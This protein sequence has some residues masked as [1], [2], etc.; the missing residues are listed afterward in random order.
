MISRFVLALA[1]ALLMLLG[2][3]TTF[4]YLG[5]K[6]SKVTV[7][8]QKPTASTPRPQAFV[9]PGT[10][11][12]AQSGALY[13]LSA[14]RFHQLTPEAGWTQPSLSPDGNSLIVVRQSHQ[15]SDVYILNRFGTVVR[16]VT[17]NAA[18]AR[19]PD[20]GANHWSFYPRLSADGQTLWMAYDEP[21][22]G[23]D[24]VLSIWAMPV[25]GSIRQGRVWTSAN[26]Y[27]GGDV[28]PVPVPQGGAIYTK[29]DYGPDLKLIGQLWYTNRAYSYGRALTTAAEDC[30]DPAVS[31]DGTQVAMICTYEKQVSYLTIASWNGSSLGTRKTIISDQLVSQPIWA[32]DGSGIAYLAPGAPAGPFQLWWLPKAAY[33]PPAPPPPPSPTPG[34]PHNGPLPTPTPPPPA[35]PVKPIQVTTNNGFDATSPMAWL[36]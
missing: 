22:Y 19:N 32:P 8:P 6:Q 17:S 15:Y 36:G 5:S 21:K 18:P 31:P 26:D 2:G 35:P 9:L 11:Y 12:L 30:R 14:G 33:L 20:T 34:G 3:T 1:L 4:I 16:Q 25:G 10:L 7:P 24:V 28:Q 29:Y 23:F 27:T 13:S